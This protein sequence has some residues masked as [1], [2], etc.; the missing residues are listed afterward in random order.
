[1]PSWWRTTIA[2][3]CVWLTI[4]TNWLARLA[5]PS[6]RPPV[7]A[8][9]A[10]LVRE[11]GQWPGVT[12]GKHRYG[13]IEFRLGRRELGHLHGDYLVDLPFPVAV[14]RRLVEGRLAL[15]HQILPRSGWVS[16]PIR[17]LAAAEDA[18]ALFR[19]SYKRAT[20]ADRT[21]GPRAS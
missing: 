7:G 21:R 15:P 16:Y 5:R 17:D 13:G 12:V 19:L 20:A 11:I 14:R 2:F 9:R 8:I 10:R 6:K 3:G 1:M 18:L 4:A